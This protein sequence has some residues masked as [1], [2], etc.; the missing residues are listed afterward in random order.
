M[1]KTFIP[2][3]RIPSAHA[4]VENSGRVKVTKRAGWEMQRRVPGDVMASILNERRARA[5][6]GLP[7]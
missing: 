1:N 3:N 7:N 2:T 5:L 6:K 4:A